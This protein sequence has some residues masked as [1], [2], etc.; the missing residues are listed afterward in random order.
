[1]WLV[2]VCVEPA[3][4][5]RRVALYEPYYLILEIRAFF[6]EG[7]LEE[8]RKVAA[9]RSAHP[10]LRLASSLSFVVKSPY[11]QKGVALWMADLGHL[12]MMQKVTSRNQM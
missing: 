12:Q 5:R 8:E 4:G 9:I 6:E 2:K 11:K 3:L 10:S 1:V 7:G